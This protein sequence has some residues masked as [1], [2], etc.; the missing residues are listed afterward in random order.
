MAF[1]EDIMQYMSYVYHLEYL[2][3]TYGELFSWSQCV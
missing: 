3:C 2:C 1:A